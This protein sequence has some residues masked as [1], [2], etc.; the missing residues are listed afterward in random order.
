MEAAELVPLARLAATVPERGTWLEVG[1]YG[2]RSLLCAGLMLA[3]GSRIIAVEN[4][5]GIRD[6]R[7]CAPPNC[8]IHPV[9][10]RAKRSFGRA[11]EWLR[12]VGLAAEHIEKESTEAARE[13]PDESLDGL[14]LDGA[15][16]RTAMSFRSA[17]WLIGCCRARR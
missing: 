10:V 9:P 3:A 13:I 4:W 15:H 2:G 16:D 11:L 14:F 17:L 5:R 1:S 8:Q 12:N 6:D 7:L